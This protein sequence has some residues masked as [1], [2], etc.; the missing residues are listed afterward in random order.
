MARGI[1]AQLPSSTSAC[2]TLSS[3]NPP[4][5][6]S[7]QMVADGTPALSTLYEYPGGL[8]QLLMLELLS[9]GVVIGMG[10]DTLRGGLAL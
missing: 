2:H 5:V 4:Y 1:G 6:S 10:Q 9:P 8:T 3:P 7:G